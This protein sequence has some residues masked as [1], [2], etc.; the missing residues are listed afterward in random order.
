M[1]NDTQV[2]DFEQFRIA[3]PGDKVRL[4][5]TLNRPSAVQRLLDIFD[6]TGALGL[7]GND[8]DVESEYSRLVGLITN[9][10]TDDAE[11]YV[12]VVVT[13]NTANHWRL[14]MEN[15]ADG[16]DEIAPVYP[17]VHES[18]LEIVAQFR[19]RFREDG[20]KGLATLLELYDEG[21]LGIA[22]VSPDLSTDDL[23]AG[24]RLNNDNAINLRAR[25]WIGERQARI[26]NLM[27]GNHPI[28]IERRL[29][30]IRDVLPHLEILRSS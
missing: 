14:I 18:L 26:A 23:L 30:F 24:F 11:G 9:G 27:A 3:E 13:P 19:I 12:E 4:H 6:H 25:Y 5:F 20:N 7:A 8:E 29:R 15:L 22:P 10:W 16:I 1:G 21:G 2:P 17:L 28:A